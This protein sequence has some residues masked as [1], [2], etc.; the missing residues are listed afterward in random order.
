[1]R[2]RMW[3]AR[4]GSCVCGTLFVR[5]H[6][7]RALARSLGATFRCPCKYLNYR[8]G[9]PPLLSVA[10]CVWLCVSLFVSTYSY[11]SCLDCGW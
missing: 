11:S 5:S 4:L 10:M 6:F 2:R 8:N 7:E 1:M 9:S 3:W